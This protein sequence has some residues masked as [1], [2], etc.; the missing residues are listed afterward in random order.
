M[1]V[2]LIYK[3]QQKTYD[4]MNKSLEERGR[5]AYVYPT[6]CGKSF[7]ALKYI[8]DNPDKKATIIV[9][10]N[11]IKKQYEKNIIK[12]VEN[13][14]EKLKSGKINIVT[15]QDRHIKLKK[16]KEGIIRRFREIR[17]KGRIPLYNGKI[18]N[19][20]KNIALKIDKESDIVVFDEIHRMGANEWEKVVDK[21]IK[22]NPKRKIIG[23]SATPERT[24]GRNMAYEKFGDDVVYEMS[25]TEA[26]SGEK[27]GEVLLKSPNYIKVLSQLKSKLPMYKEEIDLIDDDKKREEYLSVYRKLDTIVSDSPDVQDIMLAGMKKTN[28][29]YIVF[30][31]DRNDLFDKIEHAKEIFGKVNSKIN[32]DYV[33]TKKAGEYSDGKTK[34]E[35]EKTLEDFETRENGDGLNLLFCVDMLNEGVHL[36][37][38]DGEVL[39]DL[40]T[41][42]ILYK[43]RIGRVLS[44]DKEAGEV[45]IIDAANNWL[46]QIDTYKEL[47][48]AIQSGQKKNE[49]KDIDL[50][51]LKLLPEEVELLD[52]LR[53]M[54]E[55]F[56]YNQGNY[57]R[58]AIEIQKWC[59]EKYGEKPIEERALP[60]ISENVDE[61][62][63]KLAV[64]LKRLKNRIN[65]KY[66][67]VP[68]E[69]IENEEHRKIIEIMRNLEKEYG[70]SNY[71][72][73]AIK[74]QK[75]C[76]K[77]YGEKPIEERFLPILGENVDLEERKLAEKF[78]NLRNVIAKKYKG[79]SLEEIEDKEHRKIVEIVRK[80]E[81][82]Y[83]LSDSLKDVI[84]IKKWCER[85]YGEK[86]IE[87]RSLPTAGKNVDE[88]ERK[89]AEKLAELRSRIV[90]RYER[91]SVQ[92]IKDEEHKKVVEMIR[93]LDEE[94]GLS[95]SLKNAIRIQ[96][97]CE[98]NYGEKPIEERSL[99]TVGKNADAEE[100]KLTEKYNNIRANII[101]RYEGMSLEEIEDKNHRKIVEII[102]NLE[103]NYMSKEQRRKKEAKI[104]VRMKKAIGNQIQ[105]NEETRKEL[106]EKEKSVEKE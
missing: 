79:K 31:K 106:E 83:G 7:P 98:K 105:H 37:G 62:E 78:R 80:L 103:E 44:A 40:T 89:L 22:E 73:N 74:I 41:S 15:Y 104:N 64:K 92:E 82:E 48:I 93:N 3:H 52:I 13:G 49:K 24:D 70:L 57:L 72:K 20:S 12:Y 19:S 9:P 2:K 36:N 35:N 53:E 30:C 59:E 101:R 91:I 23:M 33:L 26:L 18:N 60:R 5:A 54:G 87:E 69:E 42:P 4:L 56:K 76:E 94:Y 95:D 71:L 55:I 11:F 34:K 90:K 39:F 21:I 61:E 96:K 1:A 81:E 67:G 75:W 27:E 32:I 17:K 14:E 8:E 25:L 43:Q 50:N 6:G 85:N 100:K 68:L 28:G 46:N 84:R 10:S 63:R 77:K 45:V 86:P 38:I 99:P 97:W 16:E 58:N 47:E 29:K 51:L 88:E 65:K 66:E 102:R